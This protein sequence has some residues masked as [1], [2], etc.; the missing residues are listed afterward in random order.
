MQSQ[1]QTAG[2]HAVGPVDH[3]MV[4]GESVEHGHPNALRYVQIALVLA[5]LTAVEVTVYYIKELKEPLVP[6]LLV[7]STIKFA[8]VVMFY[9]HLKFDNKL[10]SALFTLGLGLAASLML[11]LLTLFHAFLFAGGI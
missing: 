10:F 6:I 1:G 8:L 7:L 5:A 4:S 3:V 11:G 9:M 2:G